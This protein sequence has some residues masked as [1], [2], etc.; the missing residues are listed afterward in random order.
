MHV[1]EEH[2]HQG[3]NQMQKNSYKLKGSYY[4]LTLHRK[5]YHLEVCGGAM[6]EK[7]LHVIYMDIVGNFTQLR[8]L[9]DATTWY[10][11]WTNQDIEKTQ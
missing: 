11:Y 9:S 5:Q 10:L 4:L 7:C 8:F 6:T 2:E 1:K 3:Q